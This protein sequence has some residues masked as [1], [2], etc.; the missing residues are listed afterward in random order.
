M[1]LREYAKDKIKYI[2]AFLL[3]EAMA[4]FILWIIGTRQVFILMLLIIWLSPFL[5]AFFIEYAQKKKYFTEM[6]DAF[7]G[8]DQKTLL[9]EII[10]DADFVEGRKIYSILKRTDKYVNDILRDYQRNAREYK[11]YVEIWVHEVK[12]PLTSMRLLCARG[13]ASEKGRTETDRAWKDDSQKTRT[14]TAC[15]H[16][17]DRTAEKADGREPWSRQIEADLDKIEAYMEQALYYA[18]STSLEKDFF[19]KKVSLRELVSGTLKEYAGELVRVKAAVE[20][21]DLDMEVYGDPKWLSFIM[22]QILSN[23]VKYQG[24][25]KLR[26]I[27]SGE[28]E[29]DRISL[30]VEDN[31]IGIPDMDLERVFDKGFTGQNGRRVGRSTGIGLYLCKK[32]CGKMNLEIHALSGEKGACIT[33]IFPV[34]SMIE[35]VI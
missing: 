35:D 32:L 11:E 14:E 33:I 9:S 17:D 25:E 4:G 2:A 16:Q 29:K 22:R 7:L 23:S 15:I 1:S 13:E 6:E 3:A 30:K 34:N 18:R 24:K 31:G 12:V 10:C 19:V 21:R 20:L 8:L 27:F 28:K 5:C 26:L